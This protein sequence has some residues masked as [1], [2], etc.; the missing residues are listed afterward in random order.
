MLKDSIWES[1][2][3]EG[4]DENGRWIGQYMCIDCMEKALGRKVKETDLM[5]QLRAGTYF[6]IWWN[7][8]FVRRLNDGKK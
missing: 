5:L 7:E 4:F 2:S 1:I 6:H 3:S 8:R